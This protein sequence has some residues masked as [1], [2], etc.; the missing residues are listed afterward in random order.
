M[1]DQAAGV[2]MPLFDAPKD[3]EPWLEFLPVFYRSLYGHLEDKGWTERYAQ[4]QY[5]EPKD[6]ELYRRMSA[7]VHECMPGVPT[8]D[9]INS[10]PEGFSPLVDV[11]VFAVTTLAAHSDLAERRREEDRS[12]WM[13]H[14]CSPYPPYPNRH[15]DERLTDSRLYPWLAYLLKADGFLYW[16]ANKYRGADP[17]KTSIG[18]LPNG[19]QSPGHPPGDNWM[20]YPTTDGLTPGLRMIAFRDGMLDHALLTL[21]AER[22]RAA[23]EAVL[24]KVVRSLTDYEK[25]P[26]SYHR[27]R[28]ALLTALDAMP[29]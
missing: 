13:Y 9:A 5:D 28:E 25:L 3:V 1:I 29:E 19:S 12:V 27:A 22:D 7:L 2:T 26:A 4:C 15:L 14:C 18:P 23:A 24:R 17:Y 20:Y 16:A 21:L 10:N 11:H 6:T 8:K